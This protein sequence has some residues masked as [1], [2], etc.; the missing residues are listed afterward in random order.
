MTRLLVAAAM[1]LAQTAAASAASFCVQQTGIPLQCIYDDPGI[2][3]QEAENQGARCTGNPASYRTPIGN[4]Q[5]CV[6]ESGGV[7][8]CHY[9]DY[10]S[11][12]EIA[13]GRGGACIAAIP[14]PPPPKAFDPFEIKR[15]Y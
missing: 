9:P 10:S 11:C 12:Q 4:G 14:G 5:F 15:P 7:A 6:V 2:C 1:L 13:D 3:Q 8:T